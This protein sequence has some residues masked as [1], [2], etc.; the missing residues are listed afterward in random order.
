MSSFAAD[1]CYFLVRQL[2]QSQSHFHHTTLCMLLQSMVM[3]VLQCR[4]KEIP[5]LH[6]T[7]LHDSLVC[8][9][10]SSLNC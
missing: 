6:L 3:Q 8:D 1:P 9:I 5:S 2:T 10:S 7:V 4:L